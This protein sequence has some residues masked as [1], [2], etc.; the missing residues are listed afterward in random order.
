MSDRVKAIVVVSPLLSCKKAF[1]VDRLVE[2]GLPCVLV[3]LLVESLAGDVSMMVGCGLLVGG[4]VV[5]K[6]WRFVDQEIVCEV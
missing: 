2:D 1:F 5:N 3:C 6:G 4:G